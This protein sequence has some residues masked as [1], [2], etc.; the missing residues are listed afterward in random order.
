MSVIEE[1]KVGS[2]KIISIVLPS[3]LCCV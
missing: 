3:S 2:R 1:I